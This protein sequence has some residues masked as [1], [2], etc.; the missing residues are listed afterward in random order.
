MHVWR[1]E[2]ESG[3]PFEGDCFFI[4]GTGFV[5]QDLEINGEP[6]GRQMRHN[7]VIRCNAVAV[8]LGFEGLLENE[9][10]VSV[11]ANHDVL[12]ARACSDGE[13]SSVV[14]E[15]LAEWF[16]DGQRLGWKTLQREE[17]EPLEVPA[18]SAWL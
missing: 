10:A 3:I 2:F 18:K 4:G 5:I 8:A 14:G 11:E 9:V 16:C 1:D 6:P 12:V 7:G 15:E 17:V 13:A